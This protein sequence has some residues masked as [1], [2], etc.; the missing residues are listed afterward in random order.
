MEVIYLDHNRALRKITSKATIS[1]E[2]VESKGRILSYRKGSTAF[3]DNQVVVSAWKSFMGL[4]VTDGG[5]TYTWGMFPR[6]TTVDTIIKWFGEICPD[7]WYELAMAQY[8]EVQKKYIKKDDGVTGSKKRIRTKDGIYRVAKIGMKFS[9]IHIYS[10]G[11]TASQEIICT[12]D[13]QEEAEAKMEEIRQKDR[14][15]RKGSQT[16]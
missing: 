1:L 5:L 16:A 10:I 2:D 7:L 6:G 8:R 11:Y 4:S 14:K 9:V 13:T 15:S 3:V 12:T